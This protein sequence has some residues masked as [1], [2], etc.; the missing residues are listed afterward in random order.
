MDTIDYYNEKKWC[1]DCGDYVRFLM[2]VDH[3]YCVHCG[4]LVRLFNK[5]DWEAFHAAVDQ[6]R[7]ARAQGPNKGRRR[8]RA[9]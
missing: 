9:S 7:Q 2:S 1:D 3:S 6:S 5:Q 4:T 8:V